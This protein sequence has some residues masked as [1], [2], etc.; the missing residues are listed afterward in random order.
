MKIDFKHET[1]LRVRYGETDQMGYCYYGNYAQYFEVGRVE[2]M[3]KL[4]MSYKQLE[5]QGVMLPVS[6][7][8]V[9]YK[10]PAKYDD[11]LRI[12]THISELKGARLAFD[13]IIINETDQLIATAHTTLVFVAKETMRPISPPE[14]FVTII[15][16]HEQK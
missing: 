8:S 1:T 13:Y 5:E 9:K 14:S 2:A 15:E 7:F 12:T 10:H 4:G 16:P 6:E 3:R 11:A